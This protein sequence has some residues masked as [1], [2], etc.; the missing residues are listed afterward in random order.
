MSVISHPPRVPP[1]LAGHFPVS[2]LLMSSLVYPGTGQLVQR[3]WGAGLFFMLLFSVP[4]ACFMMRIVAVLRAYYDFAFNFQGATGVAPS[5]GAVLV[6]F[7]LSVVAYLAGVV[8]TAL[9]QNRLQ[10]ANRRPI[11]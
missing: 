11:S 3:R 6:P 10:Q 7:V 5:A 2:P 4:F 8:D 9:A 1:P